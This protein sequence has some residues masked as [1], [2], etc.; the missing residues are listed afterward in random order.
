MSASARHTS[1]AGRPLPGKG[2]ISSKWINRV[3]VVVIILTVGFIYW[4][5]LDYPFHFDDYRNIIDNTKIHDIKD[6]DAWW[7][8]SANRPVS[9]FSLVLNFHFHELEVRYYRI[10]NII[11]H[12]INALLVWWLVLLLFSSPVLRGTAVARHKAAIAFFTAFLFVSHPLATQS[13]TYI[14]QRHTSMAAMFYLLSLSFFIKGRLQIKGSK[15]KYFLFIGALVSAIA[16]MLSKENA[17]TLPLA[18]LLVEACFFQEKKISIGLKNYR[19]LLLLAGLAAMGV[20]LLYRFTLDI[21]EPIPETHC[22]GTAGTITPVNYL[23]T[24]FRVIAIYI[25]LLILPVNQTL[26]YDMALSQSIFQPH[27]LLSFLFLASIFLLSIYLWNKNRLFSFGILWFFITLSVESGFIPIADVIFEHRTY[28]PSFGYFLILSTGAYMIFPNRRARAAM[29]LA[30]VA[31]IWSVMAHER[32]K[33]WESEYSLWSDAIAKSPGKARPYVNRGIDYGNRQQWHK[34]IKD[35]NRAIEISDKYPIIFFRRGVAY[36]NSR[37]WHEAIDDFSR[38]E[39]FS[40]EYPIIYYYRGVAYSRTGQFEK[41]LAD[42]DR[43]VEVRPDFDL[44]YINRGTTYFDMGDYQK[45]IADYSKAIEISPQLTK[46]HLNLARAYFRQGDWQ[47]A[48]GAANNAIDLDPRNASAYFVRGGAYH[49]LGD[50][51]KA[52][53][54]YSKAIDADPGYFN[55]YLYRGD[56][57]MQMKQWDKALSDYKMAL[58]IDPGH[59]KAQNRKNMALQRV[60][61]P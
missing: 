40:S 44:A 33:V 32:N 29:V 27:T 61:R 41:A 17:Y 36:I 7:N 5:S 25:R 50:P 37:Q 47:Q 14:V 11:I 49:N 55:A 54:S 13:V 22:M 24:Q 20:F 39:R 4:G 3:G 18:I 35:Y 1:G 23:L 59:K 21:F 57:Y 46:A 60:N 19:I 26:D 2:P 45:A 58:N 48:I 56:G 8:Y 53:E 42:Y 38:I 6:V 34:A 10:V 28:L 16:G 15:L 12:I 9:M 51:E 31:L 43:F 52:I 30:V